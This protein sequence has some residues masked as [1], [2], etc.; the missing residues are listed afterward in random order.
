[1]VGSETIGSS[2]QCSTTGAPPRRDGD[3]HSIVGPLL[4]RSVSSVITRSWT[5]SST[6]VAAACRH[7]AEVA[8]AWAMVGPVAAGA[9]RRLVMVV[10]P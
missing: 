1:V 2:T 6:C 8:Q 3:G 7:A 5:P 4:V 9:P 10:T